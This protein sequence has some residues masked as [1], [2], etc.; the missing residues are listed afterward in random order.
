MRIPS[1]GGLLRGGN[2]LDLD[3]VDTVDAVDEE[4]EDEDETNLHPVLDLGD[5]GILGDEAVSRQVRIGVAHEA[6]KG[7]VLERTHVK[8][9]RL[10]LKGIG[11]MRSMNRAISTMR[12][13]KT[14]GESA[15]ASLMT[16]TRSVECVHLRECSRASW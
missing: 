15:W 10:T 12:R 11:T 4:D 6:R 1:L 2:E 3:A 16:V 13:T 9:L 7:R 5:D 14:C 8:I